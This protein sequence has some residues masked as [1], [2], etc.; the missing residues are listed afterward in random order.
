MHLTYLRTKAWMTIHAAADLQH[1]LANPADFIPARDPSLA[2]TDPIFFCVHNVLLHSSGVSYLLW[3]S[4][5]TLESRTRAENLRKILGDEVRNDVE[6]LRDR[7]FRNHIVHM[8]ERL[9]QWAKS[10]SS[11][12]LM[13]IS[14]RNL[15]GGLEEREQFEHFN[16]DTWE[17]AF[18]GDTIQ[19][20][21]LAEAV[22]RIH[23][24]TFKTDAE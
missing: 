10:S 24:A 4:R 2:P 6:M 7:K 20:A 15:F 14:K 3:P 13:G 17:L 16:P 9:D 23:H 1:R 8:D 19:L 18:R 12:G 11:I 21:A 5:D 22:Q